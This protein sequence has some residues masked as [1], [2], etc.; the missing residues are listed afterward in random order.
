M[1][2]NIKVYLHAKEINFMQSGS[3]P[4]LAYDFKKDPDW[5][6]AVAAFEWIQHIKYKFAASK[7]FRIDKVIYNEDI[8]ITGLVNKVRPILNQ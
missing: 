7:G 5:T 2:I 4:V 8:D 1:N 6:A 3:F